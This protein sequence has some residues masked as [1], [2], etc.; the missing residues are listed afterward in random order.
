MSSREL[1]TLLD[2]AICPPIEGAPAVEHYVAPHSIDQAA[3]ILRSATDHESAVLFW[4]GGTNQGQ[5]YPVAA[6]IV[7]STHQINSVVA[8]EPEDLTVVVEAGVK[9]ADLE[10]MLAEKGQT[11]VLPENPGVGTVGGAVAVGA[12][13]WRRLRYGP[14]RDRVLELILA[15]GDGRVVRSGGRLVKNVTGYDLPRLATGS[16][17][18]L[19]LIG[20]V[21]LKLW[22]LGARFSGV[23]VEDV[24][25]ARTTAFRP[26]AIIETETGV[27]VYLAGTPEEIDAQATAL[28]SSPVDTPRWPRPLVTPWQLTIRVPAGLTVAALDKVRSVS[29]ARFRAAHGTGEVL[30]GLVDL[31]FDWLNEARSWAESNGGAVVVTQR[32]VVGEVPDPW[33]S[34]PASLALERK[35]KAAFDP[36]GISNP[37][38]L[39]GGL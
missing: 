30:V 11:A 26:L 9:I 32:P 2:D 3:D 1:R 4:G 6:D 23:P 13:G 10:S 28:G 39:P 33:G 16:Y 8:W 21:C 25:M 19:G 17:G 37:G 38:R 29:G 36:L 31:S 24:A 20:Q 7:M 14:T 15:T 34:P 35:V 27:M 12:S 5:G 22:P 18:S